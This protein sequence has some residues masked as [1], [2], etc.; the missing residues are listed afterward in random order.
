VRAFAERI[1]AS[2]DYKIRD[3]NPLSRVICLERM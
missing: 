2:C 1:A 3:E